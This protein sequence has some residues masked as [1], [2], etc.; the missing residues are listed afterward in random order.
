MRTILVIRSSAMGDVAMT[1][2]VLEAVCRSYEGVRIVMLT[3]DFYRP[4]FF[5]SPN[6]DFYNV[7][8]KG[9]HG[10]LR[11]LRRLYRELR[12]KY[13]FDAVVDLHDKLYSR[14]LRWLFHID[15]VPVFHLNKG[16]KE[17][18]ALTRRHTKHK[19]QLRSSIQRYCDTFGEAGFMVEVAD[20]L[21]QRVVREIPGFVG[22]KS[23]RWIGI[24]P[25][26]QHRGKIVP[27]STIRHL[28]ERV[29]RDNANDRIFIFGGGRAEKMV[30][31]SLEA[32]YANCSSVVGKVSLSEEMDLMSHLDVMISMDSSAMHLCSLLGVR[33]VSVWGATHP[34]AGFLGLG[35]SVNDV[36]QLDMDCR[37]CSVYGNKRCYRKDYACTQ[38]ITAEMIY[39]KL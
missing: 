34:Y 7:E 28:I 26:A 3:L 16:R 25:F 23:S 31:D 24:S 35:Q 20:V 37:P 21:P 19:V 6:I 13:G 8:L 38:N 1:A 39:A 33:V 15:G 22:E 2:P 4:F 29:A 32:W 9:R 5:G 10:G 11:G 18:K 36:V 27:I 17:K 30:G 12:A 14:F